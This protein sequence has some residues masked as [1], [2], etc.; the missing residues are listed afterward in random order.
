MKHT[1]LS[2]VAAARQSAAHS[3][4]SDRPRFSRRRRAGLAALLLL[5]PALVASAQNYTLDWYSMDG[6]GGS[7]AGGAYAV[8]GTI[9]QP[10]ASPAMTGGNFSL[11][12]GFWSIVAAIQ[13]P[14]APTLS[15]ALT[16]GL[17]RVAW[18]RPAPDWVLEVTS[19]LTGAS[20]PWTEI[21]PPYQSTV[22][23]FY[24]IAPPANGQTFYRLR[25]P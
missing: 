18:P 22:T 17:V 19:T 21:S 7:S 24:L 13:T 16:N 14:G 3:P 20:P 5:T 6:G 23:H 2:P 4:N 8:H 15:V 1:N 10:D 12:S 25:K 11:T 9:G